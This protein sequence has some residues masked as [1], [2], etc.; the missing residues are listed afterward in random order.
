MSFWKQNQKLLLQRWDL[1]RRR[2]EREVAERRRDLVRRNMRQSSEWNS[3]EPYTDWYLEREVEAFVAA[4]DEVSSAGPVD[5]DD[6]SLDD[7]DR[8]LL[9]MIDR[10][11]QLA[12]SEALREMGSEYTR[13]KGSARVGLLKVQSQ[14]RSERERGYTAPPPPVR[15][16][17]EEP[18][19]AEPVAA[20]PTPVASPAPPAAASPPPV[21]PEPQPVA[22][23]PAVIDVHYLADNLRRLAQL[24]QRLPVTEEQAETLEELQFVAEEATTEPERRKL[25]MVASALERIKARIA[26]AD[27][28]AAVTAAGL[29]NPIRRWFEVSA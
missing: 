6:E 12:P 5:I 2:I 11:C 20:P 15:R 22:P 19:A 4:V 28:E 9:E 14:R 3:Y 27:P 16:K 25:R 18:P 23:E 1:H 24:I 29:A 13:V 7:M 21:E 26:A 8:M 10:R 17:S